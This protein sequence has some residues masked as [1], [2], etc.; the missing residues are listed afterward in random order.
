M[1]TF[2]EKPSEITKQ[3]WLEKLENVHLQRTDMN[4]LVMNYLVTGKTILQFNF[5]PFFLINLFYFYRRV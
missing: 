2:T 1:T 4:R 3:E 5:I